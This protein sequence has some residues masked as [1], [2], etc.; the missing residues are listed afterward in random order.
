ML[1]LVLSPVA[2]FYLESAQPSIAEMLRK[3]GTHRGILFLR[4]PL[5]VIEPGGIPPGNVMGST[6]LQ[7]RGQSGAI[8]Y[9]SL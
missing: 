2:T 8:S 7:G 3:G 9:I 4:I 6:E 5:R 1:G